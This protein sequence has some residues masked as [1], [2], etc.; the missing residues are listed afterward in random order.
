MIGVSPA[1]FLSSAGPGF[2]PVEIGRALPFLAETGFGSFQAEVFEASALGS[3]T[4]RASEAL[5]AEAKGL[6]LRCSAFVA[7]FLGHVVCAEGSIGLDRVEA[8]ARQALAAAQVLGCEGLFAVP[9]LPSGGS[10]QGGSPQGGSPQRVAELGGGLKERLG[11]LSDIARASGFTLLL[12]LV[13]GN[14]LGG[15]DDYL[16]LVEEPGLGDVGLLFD[17]G[18]AWAMGER[19]AEVPGRLGPR[20]AATHLCDNDGIT[21]LSLCPGD[22]TIPFAE[23]LSALSGAGYRGSYDVEI[24]CAPGLV[25]AEYRK[26]RDRLGT[27]LREASST[28]GIH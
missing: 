1:Y 5:A 11:R 16:R 23:V 6:G 10:P 21:N 3:W 13:P 19:V 18:H 26:A 2:G 9:L 28:R 4:D 22:G 27:A 8:S 17:T 14:V 20:L 15:I 7:H 25:Q 24:V 12:E